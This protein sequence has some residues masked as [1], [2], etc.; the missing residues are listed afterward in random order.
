[1]GVYSYCVS[2]TVTILG[3]QAK[4][5]LAAL[6]LKTSE[7]SFLEGR[8][9]QFAQSLGEALERLELSF[10]LVEG[11]FTKIQ[12]SGGKGDNSM[13]VWPML[14]PFVV[15]GSRI[16]MDVEDSRETTVFE[17]G[18]CHT[19][20]DEEGDWEDE[21]D[22]PE[23]S[24]V[25]VGLFEQIAR[26]ALS[27]EDLIEVSKS[28]GGL[29]FTDWDNNTPLMGYLESLEQDNDELVSR[30][31]STSEQ[32]VIDVLL[33]HT[34]DVSQVND[35]GDSA[36][37]L[38]LAAGLFELAK[39]LGKRGAKLPRRGERAPYRLAGQRLSSDLLSFMVDS[40][41]KLKRHGASTLVE[42]CA[43]EPGRPGKL[44]FVRQLVEEHQIDVNSSIDHTAHYDELRRGATPLM[45]AALVD[46]EKLVNYLLAQ[47]ADP[48]IAD[49]SGNTALHYCSG[50]TWP[51]NDGS[52]CWRAGR[53]NL[54]IVKILASSPAAVGCR[55]H[56]EQ[57]PYRLARQ[58]NPAALAL[59]I[60]RLTK[61]G[62]QAPVELTSDL[63]GPVEF[64]PDGKLGY[65]LNFKAG[66]LHGRQTFFSRHGHR[67]VEIDYLEG[68]AHGAYNA[69]YENDSPMMKAHCEQ[70]KWHGE[71]AMYR[72][73]GTAGQ[74]LNFQQG[75]HHGQ[76]ITLDDGGE[77]LIEAHYV[78][79]KKHG[80]FYF[81]KPDGTVAIDEEFADDMP[82]KQQR[83][84]D[85]PKKG[86][87]LAALFGAFSKSSLAA[88]MV[89]EKL[90]PTDKLFFHRPKKV[91]SLFETTQ[92]QRLS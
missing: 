87:L 25:A 23:L 69:W 58:D 66:Q 2:S 80:R 38:A 82:V 14:A 54:A 26:G 90:Q 47:E 5:A 51:G 55:N 62:V 34:K 33:E 75:R 78:D 3:D 79:G 91:L 46:D 36:A 77:I 56:A 88:E 61:W 11:D 57:S 40:G 68:V 20:V 92:A 8:D 17:N 31:P 76:Q 1:M 18:R 48:A 67:F 7:L 81:K 22:E 21:H 60:E 74:T 89:Q 42:A 30:R 12:F 72:Q 73:D 85:Q 37:S 39:Q 50:Q 63:N 6:K 64:R 44:G 35:D 27:A 65:R 70:G 24:D 43:T 16:V 83:N 4:P 71:I 41:A 15:D 84:E 19:E 13:F 45:A 52:T 9:I 86:G 10:E 59:F 53:R 49:A 32:A 29:D 28:E